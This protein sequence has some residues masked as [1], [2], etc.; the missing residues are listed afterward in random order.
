M[1]IYPCAPLISPQLNKNVNG[2]KVKNTWKGEMSLASFSL[3]SAFD[4]C[5]GL[6][7]K[8]YHQFRYKYITMT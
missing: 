4:T 8:N 3:F 1:P 2:F 6:E 5:Y 7:H